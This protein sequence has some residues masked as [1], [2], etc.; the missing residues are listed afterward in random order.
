M[1]NSQKLH[2]ELGTGKLPLIP[3]VQFSI[4]KVEIMVCLS[5][6]TWTDILVLACSDF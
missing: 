3:P 6:G 5:V 2:R 1:F 4:S